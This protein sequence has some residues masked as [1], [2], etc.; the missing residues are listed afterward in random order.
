MWNM[1][2]ITKAGGTCEIRN[3]SWMTKYEVKGALCRWQYS[4]GRGMKTMKD[5]DK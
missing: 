4:G 5:K 1:C 3:V 2:R